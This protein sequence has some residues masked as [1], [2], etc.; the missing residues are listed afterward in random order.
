MK[1]N[2]KKAIPLHCAQIAKP[3]YSLKQ[4]V[5]ASSRGVFDICDANKFYLLKSCRYKKHPI[6]LNIANRF[7]LYN[8][9]KCLYVKSKYI[10]ISSAGKIQDG[11][12][13]D[14]VS[15]DMIKRLDTR[16]KILDTL[17]Y[18]TDLDPD[19]ITVNKQI[20]RGLSLNEDSTK[21][22]MQL[23]TPDTI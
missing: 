17:E 22:N 15:L 2:T 10:F 21:N 19:P 8:I 5:N 23:S 20:E 3:V 4:A 12:V 11:V 1:I 9:T 14:S 7:R 16:S 18:N 6:T 13:I